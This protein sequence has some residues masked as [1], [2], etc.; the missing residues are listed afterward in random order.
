MTEDGKVGLLSRHRSIKGPHL[1]LRGESTAFPRVLAGK[2]GF[3][4]SYNGN[5]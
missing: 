5:F 2:L 1:T 4:L 3:H